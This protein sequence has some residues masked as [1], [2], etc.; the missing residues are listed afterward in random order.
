[1]FGKKKDRPGF[2]EQAVAGEEITDA[3]QEWLDAMI[4]ADGEIDDLERRLIARIVDEG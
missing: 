2:T 4:E 3:E 1:M